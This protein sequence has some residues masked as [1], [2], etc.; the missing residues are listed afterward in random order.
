MPKSITLKKLKGL[1]LSS[2]DTCCENLPLWENKIEYSTNKPPDKGDPIYED[3]MSED[4]IVIGWLWHSMEPRI[5]TTV[6]FC[7]SSKK[8]WESS[9]ESFL[10]RVMFLGYMRYMRSFSL[11][12]SLGDHCLSTKKFVESITAVSSLYYRFGAIEAKWEEFTIASQLSGLGSNLSGFKDRILVIET[13]PIAVMLILDQCTRPWDN[14]SSSSPGSSRGG[15]CDGRGGHGFHGR[16][17]T[18][19][20]GDKKC[21]HCGGTNHTEPYCWVKDGK[22][23]CASRH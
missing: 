21:D 7:D 3:W 12:R 14:V 2:L 20:C 6:E 4:S 18:G 9:A 1:K 10:H 5:A 15:F 17:R 11:Q 22:R 8:I 16:H 23:L 19:G 13:L